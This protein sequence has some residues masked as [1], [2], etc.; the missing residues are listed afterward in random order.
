VVILRPLPAR[1]IIDSLS[2][3]TAGPVKFAAFAR[4][5]QSANE[6]GQKTRTIEQGC[7]LSPAALG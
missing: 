1:E 2:P 3:R 5:M 6:T 7:C 4:A